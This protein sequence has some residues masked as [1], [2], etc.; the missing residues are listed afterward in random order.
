MDAVIYE[1]LNLKLTA[2]LLLLNHYHIVLITDSVHFYDFLKMV[3]NFGVFYAYSLL[4][5]YM[6]RGETSRHYLI[7]FSVR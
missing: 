3:L 1:S 6:R 5:Y 4:T 2:G 7:N